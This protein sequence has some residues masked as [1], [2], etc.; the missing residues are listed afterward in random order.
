MTQSNKNRRL[1]LAA[2]AAAATA[3]YFFSSQRSLADET[4]SANDRLRLGLIGAGGIAKANMGVSRHLLDIVQ[5]ADVDQKR[6]DA[7]SQKFTQGKAKTT[8]DYRDVIDNPN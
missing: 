1:F 8:E 3:P 6:R 4:K 2:T 5:I 7:F